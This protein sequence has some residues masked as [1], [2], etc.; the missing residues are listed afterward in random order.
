M[1]RSHALLPSRLRRVLC[2]Y[3]REIARICIYIYVIYIDVYPRLSRCH[4][5]T[6]RYG[7]F[8]LL[9][10]ACMHARITYV[11]GLHRRSPHAM[12]RKKPVKH[13]LSL[14]RGAKKNTAECRPNDKSIREQINRPRDVTC[15]SVTD[16]EELNRPSD[17]L[18]AS[19]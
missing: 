14:A 17:D 8:R 11:H 4:A 13:R 19:Q 7:L 1:Y 3:R 18:L 6:H 10:P 9:E 5:I 2:R 16:R 12:R 15:T